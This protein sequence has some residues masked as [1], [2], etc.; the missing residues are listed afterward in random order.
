MDL[1]QDLIGHIG[2]LPEFG[3]E[4]VEDIIEV[5][6]DPPTDKNKVSI[7]VNVSEGIPEDETSGPTPITFTHFV[8]FVICGFDH[9]LI[10]QK[11]IALRDELD[12][13]TGVYGTTIITYSTMVQQNYQRQSRNAPEYSTSRYQIEV[14]NT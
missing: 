1:A 2:L 11:T 14:S 5:Q 9:P 10:R 12:R 6:T 8:E 4:D 3:E 13:T 7:A